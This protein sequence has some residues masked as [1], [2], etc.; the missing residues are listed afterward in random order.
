MVRGDFFESVMV[1]SNSNG[2]IETSRNDFFRC[3]IDTSEVQLLEGENTTPK[4]IERLTLD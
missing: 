2:F 4:W 3:V 1:I